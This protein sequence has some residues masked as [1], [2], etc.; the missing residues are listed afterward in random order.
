MAPTVSSPAPSSYRRLLLPLGTMLAA[1]AIIAGSGADFTSSTSSAANVVTAGAFTQTN[2][3]TDAAIFTLEGAKP[4]DTV[5]GT[6]TV[7]NTG[8]LA[9]DFTLVEEGDTTTFPAGTLNV[10]VTD[11]TDPLAPAP[12]VSGDLGSLESTALATLE[13]GESRTYTFE[14]TFDAAAGD[15]AQGATANA[16]Y[17]WDATQTN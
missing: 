9:G 10:A 16:V 7:T 1:G 17:T 14:V 11:T 3:A 13:P 8:T 6:A 12:V 15:T 4:G 2:T 5:T